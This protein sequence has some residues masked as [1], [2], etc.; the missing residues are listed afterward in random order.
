V[1]QAAKPTS[2]HHHGLIPTPSGKTQPGHG[3]CPLPI[4]RATTPALT[5]QPATGPYVTRSCR[6]WYH[7]DRQP[8]AA[9][10]T[11]TMCA[12]CGLSLTVWK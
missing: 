1:S 11:T 5:A 12:M 9:L 3:P 8:G 10:Q 4:T 2:T 7:T 6:G